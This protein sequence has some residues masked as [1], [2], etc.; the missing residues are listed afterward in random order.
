MRHSPFTAVYDA[1]VL[2]PAPLRDL[3]MRL[4]LTGVYRARWT[5]EIHEEWKRNLLLNRADLTREQLDRTS[6]AMDRAVPDALV[7]GYEPLCHSLDL[8]DPNDRHVLA[9]AIKCGASVIVTFNLKDFP[10]ELL[11]PF[12]IEAMHP[13]DFIADLFDLDQAAVLQAAQ[14]QRA[15]L[16]NPPHTAREF[17]ERLARQGLTQSVKLLSGYERLI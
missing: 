16:K 13:D 17:L 2:Y 8:P 15:S 5:T 9:A 4:A 7:T 11:E 6:A 14:E 12:E 3:L 10:P 1:N